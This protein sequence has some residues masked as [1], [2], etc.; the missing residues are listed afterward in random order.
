MECVRT[1]VLGAAFDPPHFAHA[2]LAAIVL[3]SDV[4][5]EVW[6]CP[7]PARWDKRPRAPAEL[8]L[9]WVGKLA[10]Q[11]RAAGL[12]TTARADEISRGEFRGTYEFLRRLSAQHPDR[13][14]SLVVGA[15]A[16]AG[17]PSWRDPVAGVFN[18][19]K[20]LGEFPIILAPRDGALPQALPGAL[21]P[22][23]L[24][25]FSRFG[26]RLAKLL[27]QNDIAHLSSSAVRG[28][29]ERGDPPGS[30]VFSEL[31]R[32]IVDSGVYCGKKSI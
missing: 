15:D 21:V 1:A 23:A 27:G 16:Y 7:S 29:L 19:E 17:I 3:W 24:P 8:R 11:L 6:L 26:K 14:F 22:S 28:R 5:D 30:F 13:A 32:E 9:D 2:A 25:P 10:Q 4:A 18:G 12:K 31:Q 20:L